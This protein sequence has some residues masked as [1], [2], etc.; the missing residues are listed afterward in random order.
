ME[1]GVFDAVLLAKNAQEQ[2]LWVQRLHKKVQKGPKTPSS[3]AASSANVPGPP[4]HSGPSTPTSF[5]SSNNIIRSHSPNNHNIQRAHS[6]ASYAKVH[7][8]KLQK[9][10]LFP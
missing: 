9:K 7:P 6:S 5:A 3:I 2:A 4:T 8:I 1:T 10:C